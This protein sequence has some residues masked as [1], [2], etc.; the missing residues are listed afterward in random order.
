[1]SVKPVITLQAEATLV[2]RVFDGRRH[3][4]TLTD[5]HSLVTFVDLEFDSADQRLPQLLA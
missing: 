1:M 3:F 2:L 4:A 5:S